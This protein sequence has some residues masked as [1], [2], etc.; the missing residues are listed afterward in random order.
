MKPICNINWHPRQ[1]SGWPWLLAILAAVIVAARLITIWLGDVS[2]TGPVIV[3]SIMGLIVAAGI[4]AAVVNAIR[5]TPARVARPRR[6]EI[7]AWAPAVNTYLP[8]PAPTTS[9]TV[10]P[11]AEAPVDA[12]AP[13]TPV[14]DPI[15]ELAARRARRVA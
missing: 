13:S 7:Q 12:E 9:G 3:T 2:W 5:S 10:E 4:V 8:A 11:A 15:D 1:A 14:P 6:S